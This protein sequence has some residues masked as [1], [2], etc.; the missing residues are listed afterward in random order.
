MALFLAPKSGPSSD[1][2]TKS[3]LNILI[4]SPLLWSDQNADQNALALRQ[5]TSSE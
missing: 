3:F 5:A 2:K 4:S 1:F